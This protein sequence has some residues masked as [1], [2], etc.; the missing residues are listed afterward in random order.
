M[1]PKRAAILTD[2]GSLI[3]MTSRFTA[4]HLTKQNK[5]TKKGYYMYTPLGRYGDRG[6]PS[7]PFFYLTQKTQISQKIFSYR[8]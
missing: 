3:F 7:P 4:K 1:E 5:I 6:A 2:G 8:D